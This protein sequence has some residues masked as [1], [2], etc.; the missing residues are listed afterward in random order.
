[1]SSPNKCLVSDLL[2]AVLDLSSKRMQNLGL[3]VAVGLDHAHCKS[4]RG[5]WQVVEGTER[6]CRLD[7]QALSCFLLCCDGVG[8]R[9]AWKL[10]CACDDLTWWMLAPRIFCARS[11]SRRAHPKIVS[12]TSKRMAQRC[13]VQ[14]G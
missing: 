11:L 5:W 1:M 6:L 13:R 10:F 3:I 2:R 12:D 8:V 7:C 9:A 14:S 4:L